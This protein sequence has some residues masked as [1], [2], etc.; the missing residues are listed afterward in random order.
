MEERTAMEKLLSLTISKASFR[1]T[2]LRTNSSSA[3]ISYIHVKEK[4]KEEKKERILSRTSGTE[5]ARKSAIIIIITVI[6]S[7][8]TYLA[9][10]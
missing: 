7:I 6:A 9:C 3:I 1:K 5:S 4:E 2:R 8:C 10:I